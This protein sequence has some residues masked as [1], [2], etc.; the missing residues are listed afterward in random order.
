MASNLLDNSQENN[1]GNKQQNG[2]DEAESRFV[3]AYIFE[4][5][6]IN[7][8]PDSFVIFASSWPKIQYV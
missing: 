3:Q 6:Y 5:Y 7:F 2:K 4:I 1:G 8:I